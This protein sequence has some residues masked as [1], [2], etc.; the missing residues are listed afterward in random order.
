M[1]DC[2]YVGLTPFG[3]EHA[4]Y[5]FGRTL[6][7]AILA[8]NVLA[9]PIVVFYGASAV[10]KSSVL[11]VGLPKALRDLG[12]SAQIVSRR[13]WQQAGLLGTWLDEVTATA[14]ASPSQRLILVIDQFEEYF[15]YSDAEQVRTFTKA[16]AALVERTDI[17]VHLLI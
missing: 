15:L 1:L 8:D 11:N 14:L 16:L 12:A 2:P 4:D 3:A 13:E 7:S 9:L 17:E 6:D 5:F 10:G